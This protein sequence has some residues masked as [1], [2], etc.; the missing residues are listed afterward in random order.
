MRDPERIRAASPDCVAALLGPG[1]P[2][3]LVGKLAGT[4]RFA[5]RLYAAAASRLGDLPQLDPRQSAALA[6]DADGLR[7]I[8]LRAGA[9]WHAAAIARIVDGVARRRVMASLGPAS[10]ALALKGRDLAPSGG[11]TELPKGD[12]ADAAVA[13]G[14]CCWAAWSASQPAP[15][16]SRLSLLDRDVPSPLDHDVPSRAA[17]RN[18][19]PAIIAWLLDRA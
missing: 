18:F 1:L 3:G 13:D 10:Y 6:L 11:A 2:G 12:L 8:A 5:P 9:V 4:A 7:V 14:G 15:V 19:G 17:H 16:A